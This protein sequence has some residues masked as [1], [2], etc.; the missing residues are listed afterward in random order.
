[1]TVCQRSNS[2]DSVV[3]KRWN[4]FCDFTSVSLQDT[5]NWS[6]L[7]LTH[8]VTTPFAEISGTRRLVPGL[9]MMEMATSSLNCSFVCI[10]RPVADMLHRMATCHFLELPT[11]YKTGHSVSIRGKTRL[12]LFA[13]SIPVSRWSGQRNLCDVSALD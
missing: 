2:G 11:L 7:F 13:F 4:Y 12:S 5:S 8:R 1:M 10:N 9:V 3:S 6:S